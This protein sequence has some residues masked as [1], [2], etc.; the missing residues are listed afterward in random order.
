[1]WL[2]LE[3]SSGDFD[4]TLDDLLVVIETYRALK[5]RGAVIAPNIAGRLEELSYD[6]GH[7]RS[8]A[9]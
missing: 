3:D 2:T 5:R 6:A 8:G 1:M 9:A 7:Q 4:C